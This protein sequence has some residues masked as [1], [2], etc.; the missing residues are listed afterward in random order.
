MG[1]E[2]DIFILMRA[3]DVYQQFLPDELIGKNIYR[4]DKKLPF[5]VN[6]IY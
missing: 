1:L 5:M 3:P 6:S 4:L 2:K